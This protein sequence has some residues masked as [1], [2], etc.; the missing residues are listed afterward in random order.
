MRAIMQVCFPR[1]ACVCFSGLQTLAECEE[2]V[3]GALVIAAPLAAPVVSVAVYFAA[4]QQPACRCGAG[5]RT[6]PVPPSA[7]GDAEVKE[8]KFDV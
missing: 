2:V 4:T 5:P 6:S 1:L 8:E 3:R 7:S